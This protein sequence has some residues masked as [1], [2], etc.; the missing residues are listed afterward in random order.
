MTK[1]YTYERNALNPMTTSLVSI[2]TPYNVRH[3]P[4]KMD[5]RIL[6]NGK[7]VPVDPQARN[8]LGWLRAGTMPSDTGRQFGQRATV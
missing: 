6:T 5:R 4:S 8:V 2:R 1:T 7:W 3:N